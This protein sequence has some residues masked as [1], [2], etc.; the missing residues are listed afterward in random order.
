MT[1]EELREYNKLSPFDKT[2]YNQYKALHPGD[3]HSQAFTYA[4]ICGDGGIGGEINNPGGGGGGGGGDHKTKTI[5]ELVTEAIK[6]AREFIQR[7]VPR[8]FDQVRNVFDNLLN[9]LSRAIEV[10]WETIKGWFRDIF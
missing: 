8:I 6:K 1:S 4:T 10:T 7:E 3:S 9:R 5:K 2:L